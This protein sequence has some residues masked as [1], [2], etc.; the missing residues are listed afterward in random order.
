MKEEI[1]GNSTEVEK[2]FDYII[3]VMKENDEFLHKNSDE[4]CNEVIELVN[5]AID[6][7]IHA[8]E[9][10]GRDRYYYVERSM[11]FFLHHILMP[12]SYGIY[13]DLLAGNLPVCFMEL[14]LAVES[15][16]KCYLAD[17]KFPGQTF[18]QEK[19]ELLEKELERKKLSTSK[20]MEELGNRLGED[21]FIRLWGKLSRD[22]VHTKGIVDRTVGQIGEKSDVPPWALPLPMAYTENDLEAVDELC[23]RISQF[24]SLLVTTLEKY[25]Q[26]FGFL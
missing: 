16:A 6:Y 9:K 22:W 14:R 8:V 25:K 18:F 19:L 20:L 4:T 1:R 10:W 7:V 5:D 2:Y 15:L 12:F 21:K 17:L 11:A 3:G 24:R 13:V 26:E 23:K